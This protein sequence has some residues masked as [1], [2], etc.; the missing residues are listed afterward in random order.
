MDESR[1][2]TSLQAANIFT[3]AAGFAPPY[4]NRVVTAVNDHVVR[5]S[6]MTEPFAWH[7]HP[8]S[9]ETFLCLEGRLRLE[10][11]DR[12]LMLEPGDLV[13]VPA[14]VAHRTSPAGDRSVNIT[15]ERAALETVWL[16]SPRPLA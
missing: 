11:E 1:Q 3:L 16:R 14:G 5:L 2:A 4:E 12:D 8:N 7:H 6:V 10:L 15:V 9:A 13:T